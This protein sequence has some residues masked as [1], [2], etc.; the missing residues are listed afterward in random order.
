MQTAEHSTAPHARVRTALIAVLLI[1]GTAIGLLLAHS[2]E[3]S[4]TSGAGTVTVTADVHAGMAAS[5]DGTASVSEGQVLPFG[6]SL[7]LCVSI[8][9]GCV[10]ALLLVFLSTRRPPSIETNAPPR[11]AAPRTMM[12]R[13]LR[14]P[15]PL[16]LDA[17]CISR[18]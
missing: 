4:H 7:A 17:L 6:E 14:A 3:T 15:T 18:V 11:R 9:L 13:V 5:D 12:V 1:I 2:A 10:T 16:S 8:G